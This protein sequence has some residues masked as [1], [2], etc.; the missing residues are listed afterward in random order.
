LCY[1]TRN[2]APFEL[3]GEFD[4]WR[5]PTL[6]RFPFSKLGLWLGEIVA[7]D[8]NG[9][10]NQNIELRSTTLDDMLA[11]VED[12]ALLKLD[13]EELN[14]RLCVVQRRRLTVLAQSYLKFDG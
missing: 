6:D 5:E 13:L 11:G 3:F 14:V 2:Q 1:S 8:R 7:G 12:I 10:A 9:R 4:P